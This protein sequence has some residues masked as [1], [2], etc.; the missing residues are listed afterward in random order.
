MEEQHHKRDP[1][2][3]VDQVVAASEVGQ[4]VD[5]DHLQLFVSPAGPGMGGQQD[6]RLQQADE[7]GRA[8]PF[9]MGHRH[10][11]DPQFN[12]DTVTHPLSGAAV[13]LR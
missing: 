5:Q 9:A 3:Q 4:F 1:L 8:E 6:Q 11:M 13:Q 10:R 7:H 2:Q 12:R